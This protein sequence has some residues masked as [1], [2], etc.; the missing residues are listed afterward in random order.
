MIAEKVLFSSHHLAVKETP[1]GFQYLE[2]R[3]KDSIGIFLVRK[4]HG[5]LNGYEVLIRMQPLC[6]NNA[7]IDGNQTLYACPLTGSVEPGETPEAAAIRET[8]E[9]SGYPIE[10]NAL[11]K[12]GRYIVGTQTNEICYLFFSDVTD[13]NP[14]LATQD[15]TY[16]ESVSINKWEPLE[17]LKECDYAGCQLGY[18]KLKALLDSRL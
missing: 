4:I 9:E 7:E 15:G 17:Y 6:I 13:I 16:F 3:G 2:R 14:E 18:Y 8:L 1:R 5:E 12:I 11:N 10:L